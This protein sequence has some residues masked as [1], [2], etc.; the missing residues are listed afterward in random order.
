MTR[1]KKEVIDLIHSLPADCTLEDIQY[2]LYVKEKIERG[3][4]AVDDGQ[5]VPQKE[6]EKRIKEWLKSSGQSQL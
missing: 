1:I 4:K 5:V 3:I 6:A 2:H